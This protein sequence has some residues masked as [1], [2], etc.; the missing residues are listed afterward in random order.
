MREPKLFTLS[1]KSIRVCSAEETG[2]MDKLFNEYVDLFRHF[3]PNDEDVFSVW[4]QK[5]EARIH[6]EGL[7]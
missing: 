6:N 2:F 7:R 1:N 4:N 5:T 3:H